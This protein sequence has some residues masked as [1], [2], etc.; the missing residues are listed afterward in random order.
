MTFFLVFYS[1]TSARV[2]TNPTE[3]KRMAF[4]MALVKATSQ[5]R[6]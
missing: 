6:C 3:Q 4:V 5:T 2:N 1:G